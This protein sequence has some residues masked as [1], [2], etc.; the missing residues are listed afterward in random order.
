MT[1]KELIDIIDVKI[2]VMG[3][4]NGYHPKRLKP[5]WER[6]TTDSEKLKVFIDYVSNPVPSLGFKSLLKD[7]LPHKTLESIIIEFP[8]CLPL[9]KDDNIKQIC[10][11]KFNKYKE[12]V[13]YMNEKKRFDKSLGF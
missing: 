1:V 13:W 7:E 2:E 10:I 5:K 4:P 11:E 12:G 3:T 6:L 9:L 8:N